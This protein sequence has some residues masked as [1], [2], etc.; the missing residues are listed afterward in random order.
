MADNA[1]QQCLGDF[2]TGFG[3]DGVP[4]ARAGAVRNFPSKVMQGAGDLPDLWFKERL[5]VWNLHGG[6]IGGP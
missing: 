4:E 1:L 3:Q 5:G 6:C 2:N